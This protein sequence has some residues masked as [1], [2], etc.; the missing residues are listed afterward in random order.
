MEKTNPS[1]DSL[2]HLVG[3]LINEIEG[4][5][6]LVKEAIGMNPSEPA[7]RLVAI[8]EGCKILRRKKSTVYHMV[9][10]GILPHYKVGKMLEFRPSELIS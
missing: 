2:P 10:D 1:F 6:S 4:L 5:K 3:S 9:R 8:D 7:N